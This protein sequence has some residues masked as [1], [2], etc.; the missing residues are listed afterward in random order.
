MNPPPLR[1]RQIPESVQEDKETIEPNHT[2]C[3]LFD[4]GRLNEYLSDSQR[5]QFVTEAC[6]VKDNDHT[7]MYFSSF[8]LYYYN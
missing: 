8:S 3:I 1:E 2:H 4:S 5:K 7:C 6:K